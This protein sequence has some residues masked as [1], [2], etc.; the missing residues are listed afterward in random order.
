MADY[1]AQ[2][3]VLDLKIEQ[4]KKEYGIVDNPNVEAYENESKSLGIKIGEGEGLCINN[5]ESGK[6]KD[7]PLRDL[8]TFLKDN[9]D[10]RKSVNKK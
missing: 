2:R 7:A 1:D 6:G 10:L 5:G 3:A 8:E 9:E 4:T